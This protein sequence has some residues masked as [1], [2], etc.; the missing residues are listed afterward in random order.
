MNK[1]QWVSI[2]H[3]MVHRLDRDR[4]MCAMVAPPGKRNALVALLA[5]N[6]EIATIPELVSEPML[7]E[8]RLQWWRETVTRLYDGIRVDHPVALGLAEA[9][10]KANLSKCLIEGYLDARAFDLK[11]VPPGSMMELEKYAED[12][13][14]ALHILMAEVLGL[15]NL[16]SGQQ[17]HVHEAVRHGGV[18]WAITGLLAT[19]DFHVKRGRS[20]LPEDEEDGIEALTQAAERHISAARSTRRHV[21]K[22]MLPVLLPVALA[23]RNLKYRFR[24]GASRKGLGR[25]FEF[26][27][28]VILGKY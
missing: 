26:Y 4:L 27:W 10:E 25:L 17:L 21:P 16:V 13:A 19:V 2:C 15:A 22:S 12:T 7:G 9:I 3:G 6:L 28:N 1:D 24:G 18:A 8:I 5:F 14:G 20:F 11:G 23:D